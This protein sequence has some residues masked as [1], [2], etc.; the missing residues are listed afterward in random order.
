MCVAI[1]FTGMLEQ[2][3]TYSES[4]FQGGSNDTNFSSLGLCWAKKSPF[5][6]TKN[7][8]NDFY[9]RSSKDSCESYSP[10]QTVIAPLRIGLENW[11]H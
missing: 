7:D 2:F 11:Y 4:S 5:K 9:L 10:L 6:A 8:L 1:S 3:K